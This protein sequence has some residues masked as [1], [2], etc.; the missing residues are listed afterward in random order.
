MT[1]EQSDKIKEAFK[2]VVRERVALGNHARWGESDS[3]AVVE[4]LVEVLQ[5]DDELALEG[6]DAIRANVGQVVNPSAFAQVLEKLPDGVDKDANGVVQPAHP[7]FIRRPKRGT[8]GSRA[9]SD[10]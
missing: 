10:L 7:S 6:F 8:G 3:L 1:K 5:G 4:K 9:V 2:A